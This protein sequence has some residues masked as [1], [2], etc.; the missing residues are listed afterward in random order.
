MNDP[1]LRH[2]WPSNFYL[3]T[4]STDDFQASG[5]SFV[6][7]P[8]ILIGA[9]KKLAWG[10]T[11][12]YLNTQDSVLLK[13]DPTERESYWVDGKKYSLEKWPQKFCV[14]KKGTCRDEEHFVS[15]FGPVMDSRHEPW[16][17][18][19]DYLAIMWTGFL[20][21]QHRKITT[22]F[23]ELAQAENV[24]SAEKIIGTMT[25]P[26]VNMVLA[27]SQANIGYAYAGLVPK[28]DK[29]QHA[30]LPLDGAKISSK[31]STFLDKPYVTNPDAGF[32]ITA[33]QNIYSHGSG[34]SKTQ[35]MQG[36]PP[37]RALE[38][39]KR[40]TS[41]LE[42]Q[43]L[44][45]NDVASIQ[46]DS[47][48]V[49]AKELAPSLGR[50]C[51]ESFKNANNARQQFAKLLSEFDGNF[52]ADSLA[53]LPYEITVTDIVEDRL[54]PAVGENLAMRFSYVGQINYAVKLA[55]LKELSGKKSALFKELKFESIQDY[56]KTRC[57][58]AF[59][60]L[61]KMAGS[62]PWQWRWGR[63][64]YLQ[65]QSPLA[66]APVVGGFFRD[67]KREVGGTSSSPLAETGTPVI[68]GANMRFQARMSN[69]P[70]LK[71]SLDSGNSGVVGAKNSLDQADLWHKGE[72]FKLVTDWVQAEEQALSRFRL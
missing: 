27:D 42:D 50:I 12:S 20:T 21:D 49:E 18:K 8:A 31:W 2:N 29:A 28:R 67:R 58:P 19:N 24:A 43:P 1:H 38:I 30:F 40:L 71:F 61:T 69:P 56:L 59:L 41:Y 48:S 57:E 70:E 14:D 15:I 34:D 32:I 25:F 68:Y 11:A 7:L 22:S 37:F 51:Q 60:R 35:G 33:N 39:K 4:L 72:V 5:A 46:L 63:H 16:I 9:S 53:A 66:Q 64:H 17:D 26:G 10:V 65:R 6:G 54:K 23:I 36:A 47:T 44:R 45:F 3:A 62:S 52:S 13:R 55:L